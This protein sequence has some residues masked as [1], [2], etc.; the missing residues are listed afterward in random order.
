MPRALVDA[1]ALISASSV[2][3]SPVQMLHE[4]YDWNGRRVPGLVSRKLG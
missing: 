2:F 3:V 1:A 4:G